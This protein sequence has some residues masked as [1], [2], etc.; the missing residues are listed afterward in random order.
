[1]CN[2]NIWA[3]IFSSILKT[4]P[5]LFFYLNNKTNDENICSCPGRIYLSLQVLNATPKPQ[6]KHCK[7]ALEG[8][9]SFV[10]HILPFQ[11]SRGKLTNICYQN[12]G[13][14][15]FYHLHTAT[16][17]ETCTYI[18]NHYLNQEQR[19]SSQRRICNLKTE[20]R[21]KMASLKSF[22]IW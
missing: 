20:E 1:M 9:S 5:A 7:M 22:S 12:R 18:L 19:P 21:F 2:Q 8:S 16:H 4:R 15:V 13:W 17:T 6:E 10:I 11:C 14:S 3:Q